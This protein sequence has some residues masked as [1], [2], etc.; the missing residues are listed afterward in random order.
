MDTDNWFA[1]LTSAE[2]GPGV[3]NVGIGTTGQLTEAAEETLIKEASYS[4]DVSD[5]QAMTVGVFAKSKQ[6]EWTTLLV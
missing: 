5:S 6:V 3:F 2:V 1:G 4:F